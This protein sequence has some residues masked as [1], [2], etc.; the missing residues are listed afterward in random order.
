MRKGTTELVV[1]LLEV[2]VIHGKLARVHHHPFHLWWVV[3]PPREALLREAWDA[4][5]RTPN[6]KS[7]STD[8]KPC[9]IT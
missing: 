8:P 4:K 9:E 5:P 1:I 6:P 2:G 3:L 7:Q